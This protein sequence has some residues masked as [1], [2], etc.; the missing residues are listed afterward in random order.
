MLNSSLNWRQSSY[1]GQ[2]QTLECKGPRSDSLSTAYLV[3]W[4]WTRHV[5][6]VNL[7]TPHLHKKTIPEPTSQCDFGDEINEHK[8]ESVVHSQHALCVTSFTCKKTG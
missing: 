4:L 3:Q 1:L 8:T 6:L 5:P 7:R 2:A